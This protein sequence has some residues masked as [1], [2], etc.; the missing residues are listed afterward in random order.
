M[1]F[2]HVCLESVAHVLPE[3][4][5]TTAQIEERLAPLYERLRLPAGRLE[6]MSGIRERRFFPAGTRPGDVSIRTANLAIEKS[7]LSR[8]HF[9]ALVHG[10]VCRDHLE[11][12]TACRVH[13]ET[14]LPSRCDVFDVSNACLGVLTGAVQIAGMIELGHIDAGVVVGTECGRSLVEDT[15]A[16]LNADESLTRSAVKDS[17]ASLTIGSASAAMVLCH[18]R[19]SQTGNRLETAWRLADTSHH[20]LCRSEGLSQAMRTDSE[21]LMRA[22]VA[23]GAEAFEGFLQESGWDR[24]QI[25]RTVC[26]Q[27]G[28][29]HRKMMLAEMS[30]DPAKDF[31]TLEWLGNTGAAALPSAVSIAEESGAIEAGDRVALLGIGS[32]VNCLMIGVD[33]RT[34][35][36][37]S[38]TSVKQ[39]TGVL[40]AAP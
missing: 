20:T 3:E 1:R 5:V 23:L 7:G 27:V 21:R 6:L 37:A 19:L 33:W 15:I 30:L 26:H 9:G 17:I 4:A 14:G 18:E 24:Q 36:T 8:E 28:A 35:R 22:G 2:R 39:Q 10:S 40:G 29:A 13:H 25:D 38:P 31:A 11:P 32:G 34:V 16:S 12:A